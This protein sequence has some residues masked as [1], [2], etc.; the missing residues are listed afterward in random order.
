M[1]DH[2]PSYD[3]HLTGKKNPWRWWFEE[4]PGLTYQ[5]RRPQMGSPS[6][7]D[8]YR[9]PSTEGRV[10]GDY[11]LAN[12]RLAEQGQTPNLNWYDYL[13]DYPFML[14]YTKRSPRQRG[15]PSDQSFAPRAAWNI[16]PGY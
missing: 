13:A 3:P 9:A 12:A 15:E 10:F 2:G 6:F 8:Y 4:S 7:Q 5:L 11:E 14:E 1:P 16:P